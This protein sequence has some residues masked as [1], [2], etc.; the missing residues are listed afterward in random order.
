MVASD[1]ITN[2]GVSIPSLPH[3]I[4]SLGMA[5]EYESGCRITDLTEV[6]PKRGVFQTKIL[7]HHGDNADG[8]ITCNP[9]A[10]LEKPN[11]FL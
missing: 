2:F 5:P 7:F 9:A 1:S 3:V 11:T 8:E 10:N 4:F 6:G